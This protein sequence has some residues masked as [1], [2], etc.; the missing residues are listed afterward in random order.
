MK[1]NN[2]TLRT[3]FLVIFSFLLFALKTNAQEKQYKIA[4]VAFY[5]LENLFDT[6]DTPDKDDFEYTPEGEKKW[7]SKKYHSKLKNMSE[8]IAQIGTDLTKTAPAIIGVS[9]IENKTVLEDLVKMPALK[10]YN[11]KVVHYE[12]PDKRGV[13]V[14]LL[15]QSSMFEVKNTVSA[16]LTIEGRDDFFSRDQLVVSGELDGEM[17]H[18]IVNHWPSRYGGE[19]NSRPRRNAAAD[20]TRSLADSIMNLDENAKIIIV[21]DLN[22]DPN[23][24]SLLKHLKAKKS[25]ENTK[26]GELYN[27]TYPL[28]QKGVGT[29]AYRDNWNLFDQII[30]S[31]PLIEDDK[32]SFKYYKTAIFD[33]DFLKRDNGRYKGYPKRTHGGGVY[34]NGYSDHFPVYIY[35]IK[36]VK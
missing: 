4:T 11:Y 27:T 18:I 16:T 3:G 34:L 13:D 35:L 32:S 7:D 17:I 28:F 12:S 1:Q 19:K 15:Y 22:D 8:V 6:L 20:L 9:E 2:I 10:K 23:N 14:G 33:K 24:E 21:G 25:K 36:E 26:P 30:V 5:N 29:L 31:Y